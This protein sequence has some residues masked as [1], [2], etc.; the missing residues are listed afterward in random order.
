MAGNDIMKQDCEE[1][2]FIFPL[3]FKIT[4]DVMDNY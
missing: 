3:S 2:D 4:S 1:K